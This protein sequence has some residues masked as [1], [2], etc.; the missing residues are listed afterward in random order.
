MAKYKYIGEST[1]N[2]QHGTVLDQ[3]PTTWSIKNGE[4]RKEVQVLYVKDYNGYDTPLSLSNF[5]VCDGDNLKRAK[6]N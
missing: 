5:E 6:G 4:C 1:I 3:E 2:I